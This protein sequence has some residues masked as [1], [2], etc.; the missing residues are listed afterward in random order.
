MGERANKRSFTQAGRGG[1]GQ[2][3]GARRGRGG[4]KGASPAR[5]SALEAVRILRER[6]AFAQEVMERT[7][8]VARLSPEDRA[9]ATRL[10]LGVV[11]TRGVLDE[12]LDRCMRTPHD[13]T[14]DVRD[15]LQISAYE[16]LFLDKSP[17][18]AV[19]QGVELVRGIAPRAGGVA[20]A[21]LRKVVASKASFPFGNPAT[22]AAAYARLHGFPAWLAARLMADLGAQ[23]AHALIKASNEPAPLY[24]AVCAAKATPEVEAEVVA[25]LEAAHAAPKPVEVGGARVAGCYRLA[26]GRALLDARVKRHIANGHLLIS[27]AASQAVANLVLP[28]ARPASFLEVGAGRG[29]KTVLI[30]GNARRRYGAQI[31]DYVTIDNHGFKTDLLVDRA[32]DY[33]VHLEEAL[34]GDAARLDAAVGDRAFDVVFI[35]APCSGLGTLRRHPEI[36]WRLRPEVVTDHARLGLRLLESAAAHVAPG[37]LLAYAT[38]T[39]LPEENAHVV[40]SFLKGA[41]GAGFELVPVR[42]QAAFATR[43]APGGTDGHFCA[44]MRRKAL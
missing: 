18:A 2:G 38:C 23:D 39:V 3:G 17:H 33:G 19:D 24:A 35:D 4:A 40:A 21:V 41:R 22:D 30:Q 12:V 20:N 6:D 36:R 7:V 42:G 43:V 25:D 32:A 27:D 15:A 44:I 26:D 8:D 29:T 31:D 16:I 14:P 37:G 28:E 5:T 13:V 34:T 1:R 9:F 11:S 10:V